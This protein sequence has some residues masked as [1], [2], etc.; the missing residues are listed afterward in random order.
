MAALS[1][2]QTFMETIMRLNYKIIW[3]LL[4]YTPLNPETLFV[5]RT[6]W[7]LQKA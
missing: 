3:V 6:S 4:E 1:L 7:L 2:Y 5:E